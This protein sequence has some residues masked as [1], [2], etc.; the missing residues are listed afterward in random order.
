MRTQ[1]GD[2]DK[3]AIRSAEYGKATCTLTLTGELIDPRKDGRYAAR[4]DKFKV[5]QTGANVK[6]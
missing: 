5:T 1:P 4:R 2:K 6:D 3:D